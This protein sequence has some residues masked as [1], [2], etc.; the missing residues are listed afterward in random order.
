[1][2]KTHIILKLLLIFLILL[3]SSVYGQYV[4]SDTNQFTIGSGGTLGTTDY[5]TVGRPRTP[6]H[7]VNG[8]FFYSDNGGTVFSGNE[9]M[10]VDTA[11]LAD[12]I[13]WDGTLNT[14]PFTPN[15][16]MHFTERNDSLWLGGQ[17]PSGDEAYSAVVT[18]NPSTG[19]ITFDMKDT[20]DE[21]GQH[22]NILKLIPIGETDVSVGIFRGGAN[23]Y[24]FGLNITDDNGTTWLYDSTTVAYWFEGDSSSFTN[25]L[26]GEIKG[27]SACAIMVI[28]GD[29]AGVFNF[30]SSDSTV[31]Q[32]GNF[33][34]TSR[35]DNSLSRMFNYGIVQDSVEYL[36]IT[37]AENTTNDSIVYAYK[38][39][40][41]STWTEGIFAIDGDG[42][43]DGDGT[44]LHTNY[45]DSLGIL[46]L[47]Y[48]REMGDGTGD[49]FMRT[50]GLDGTPSD[51]IAIAEG[52]S[53]TDDEGCAVV[54]LRE[55]P[56][57]LGNKAY[58]VFQQG[59]S[60][61]LME[62]TV[63]QDADS[64]WQDADYW[65]TSLPDTITDAKH[66]AAYGVS[67]TYDTIRIEGTSLSS[68]NN[69]LIFDGTNGWVVLLEDDTL[70]FGTDSTYQWLNQS[71]TPVMRQ[72]AIGICSYPYS[73]DCD[74]ITIKGGYI[75]HRPDNI[76]DPMDTTF[77]YLD[78][79]NWFSQCINLGGES[80]D[81]LLDSIKEMNIRGLCGTNLRGGGKGVF[82]RNCYFLNQ[83]Y[84]FRDRQYFDAVGYYTQTDDGDSLTGSYT[85][86][87]LLYGCKMD[88]YAH[89]GVYTGYKNSAYRFGVYKI[90]ACTIMVD[91]RN[92]FDG[93]QATAYTSTTQ[94]YG[95]FLSLAGH[96]NNN[97]SSVTNCYIYSGD[98]FRG[99]RGI[100]FNSVRGVD[101]YY[102]MISGNRLKINEGKSS[103]YSAISTAVSPIKM[104]QECQYVKC[105]SNVI[106][107]TLDTTTAE[108]EAYLPGGEC[109]VY[110]QWEDSADMD[111][112]EC[113][114]VIENNR[115]STLVLSSDASAVLDYN[116]ACFKYDFNHQPDTTSYSRYNYYVSYA[117]HIYDYGQF[118]GAASGTL[119]YGDTVVLLND[120]KVSSDTATFNLGGYGYASMNNMAR[121]IVYM[122]NASPNSVSHLWRTSPASTGTEKELEVYKTITIIVED[123]LGN[124]VSSA[125]VDIVN[126]YG[127]TISQGATNSS[128]IYTD[129]IKYFNEFYTIPDSSGYNNF[130]LI[131][132]SA[133]DSTMGTYEIAWDRGDTTLVLATEQAE[134]PASE[135]V[136]KYMK[137]VKR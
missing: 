98:T 51:E 77:E 69:G 50:F 16:H 31:T 84:G 102:A 70:I 68:L 18:V 112:T 14:S 114:V 109:I 28:A 13:S 17:T 15:R 71:S 117:N 10:T 58:V 94:S 19:A 12:P 21:Y 136:R 66:S 137:G 104:R 105:S 116:G 89:C 85:Y 55:T 36:F 40:G 115:C 3:S 26:G 90:E 87:T 131:A 100:G 46:C 67:K 43:F 86:N 132:E 128:G 123:T 29:S 4:V 103:Q 45:I 126:A 25:R 8:Y 53:V 30:D 11:S 59:T 54:G 107:L 135:S 79:I 20:V 72:G 24:D 134:E 121:D 9:F 5:F 108:G 82:V 62:V 23:S 52:L 73:T 99:G 34:F 2:M 35:G 111:F 125:N 37:N 33:M 101:G 91:A 7:Y 49:L 48:A 44:W 74:S 38:T 129:L 127:D 118:D 57:H 60:V 63:N 124:P 75:L 83:S 78:T 65:V 122:E 106:T 130:T 39:L 76:G 41:G 88:I 80:N 42:E 110:Q 97:S 22:I 95:V 32:D 96:A 64:T 81:I 92:Y 133:G 120:G 113:Y 93:T 47:F 6:F 56:S 119:V 61:E 27:S 1:M